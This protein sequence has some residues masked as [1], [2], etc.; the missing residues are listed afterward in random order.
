VNDLVATALSCSLKQ[1]RYLDL[2]SCNMS[3][4]VCLAAIAHLTQLTTLRLPGSCRWT[5]QGL[6]LLTRLSRL[7]DFNFPLGVFSRSG[8]TFE[9]MQQFRAAVG[10]VRQQY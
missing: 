8:V 5:Q 9:M 4:M 1:L 2:S 6:M 7:Q 10:T 3:S